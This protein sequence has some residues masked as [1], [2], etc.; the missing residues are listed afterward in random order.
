MYK[1]TKIMKS[2]MY[3]R[4]YY[5]NV[6][7]CIVTNLINELIVFIYEVETVTQTVVQITLSSLTRYVTQLHF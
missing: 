3:G 6:T 5:K 4:S 7:H 1:I 2:Y